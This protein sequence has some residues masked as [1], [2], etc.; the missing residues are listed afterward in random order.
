MQ[1]SVI[2]YLFFL[3]P[4]LAN[5]QSVFDVNTSVRALGMGGAY[6]AVVDDADSLFYNPASLSKVDGMIWT[7][8]DPRIGAGNVEALTSVQDIQ[9][10]DNIASAFDGLYGETI[11]LSGGAKSALAFPYFGM[12]YYDRLNVK[13]EIKDPSF[14]TLEASYLND[15]G[16]NL[17]FAFPII[18]GFLTAGIV[19]KKVTRTGYSISTSGS[20]LISLD[21]DALF[22]GNE[23]IGTG[24][25]IDYGMNLSFP[26]PVVT[27]TFSFVWR[28]VGNTIYK[29][30]VATDENPPPDDGDMIVGV[31]VE[32]DTPIMTLTP[33]I[34]IRKLN[35][36]GMQLG[37]KI[38]MGLE[39]SLPFLDL[40]GGFYQGYYSMGAG[41]S[42]GPIRIDLATYGEELGEYPGQKEDRRYVLQITGEIGVGFGFLDKM[43]GGS[44]S[45]K[46]GSKRRDRLKRRR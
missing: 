29:A 18:P 17:G 19:I 34:E 20:S 35:I 10:P 25:G 30:D 24:Y 45:K 22:N 23:R 39:L 37:K 7:I 14:P 44:S 1:L 33:T 42:L 3:I 6:I 12:S 46:G 2:L 9:D 16:L 40:R 15:L 41:L 43:T 27:P 28:D 8:V 26:L 38:H 4:M 31:A 13:L 21:P 36:T 5:A 32:V 11:S